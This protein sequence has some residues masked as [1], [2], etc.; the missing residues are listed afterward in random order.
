MGRKVEGKE[1]IQVTI[2]DKGWAE[3]EWECSGVPPGVYFILVRYTGGTET[4]PVIV[5]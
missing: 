5:E 3:V 1:R 4:I 2:R